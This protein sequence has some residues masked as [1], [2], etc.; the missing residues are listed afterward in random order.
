MQVYDGSLDAN[1]LVTH[2][3]PELR[4]TAYGDATVRQVMDMTIGV[5]YSEA[6]ADPTADIHAYAP[7]ASHPLAA[8]VFMDPTSLPA[9]RALA[10]HLMRG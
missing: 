9:Y 4:D 5:R 1:A 10:E 8:N 2:Y 3:V 6:Y 7:Y